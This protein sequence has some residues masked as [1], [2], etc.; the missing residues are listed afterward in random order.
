MIVGLASGVV[1]FETLAPHLHIQPVP[2]RLVGVPVFER[3]FKPRHL[4][5]ALV[6]DGVVSGGHLVP[7]ETGRE[8]LMSD[9]DRER[10]T[11]GGG[12]LLEHL[13]PED[14]VDVSV[15]VHGGIQAA[16]VPAANVTVNPLR[17]KLVAGVDQ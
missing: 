5:L 10:P 2:V 1:Q 17:G 15:R 3:P 12:L 13:D 4:E 16:G 8:C 14:V 6:D 11:V 7:I 9:H